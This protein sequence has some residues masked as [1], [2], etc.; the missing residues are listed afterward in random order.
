[1]LETLLNDVIGVFRSTFMSGDWV[2]LGIAAG[3][4][5][6]ASL[7]MQRGTQVASMT[8]LA[9][10]LFALG[11]FVRGVIGGAQTEGADPAGAAAG[12]FDASLSQFSSMQA[13][14]LLAY[15][16]AFMVLILVIFLVKSVL[17]RG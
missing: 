16:L 12:Q 1:M 5:I 9:L 15:F 11:G 8:L 17:N 14:S 10:V 13:G 2:G 7:I 4:V 3:S 6:V